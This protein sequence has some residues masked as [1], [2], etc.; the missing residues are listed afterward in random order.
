MIKKILNPLDEHQA[1]DLIESV[2]P[3]ILVRDIG[4]SMLADGIIEANFHRRDNW[5]VTN[6]YSDTIWFQ[7][8]HYAAM[9]FEKKKIWLALDKQLIEKPIDNAIPFLSANEYGWE[10]YREGLS[11][12][13]DKHKPGIPF[14]LNGYYLPVSYESH[15]EIWPYMRR[16]FFEFIFKAEYGG[17]STML[18]A[19]KKIHTPGILMYL[20]NKKGMHIPDPL[21]Q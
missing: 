5:A 3:D 14:S 17:Q 8:G 10:P 21:Y 2:L 11:Q 9:T 13:K 7:V 15:G 18:P 19:T 4:L 1:K 16:L 12:F 6:A 20:R